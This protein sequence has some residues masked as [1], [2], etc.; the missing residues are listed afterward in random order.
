MPT[1]ATNRTQTNAINSGATSADAAQLSRRGVLAGA[2]T[3][4]VAI[5][6]GTSLAKAPTKP[7]PAATPT[8]P[9]GFYRL[10]VGDITGVALSDGLGVNPGSP[11]PT[12]AP[13]ATKDEVNAVLKDAFLPE[14]RFVFYFNGL[15]LKIGADLILIDAG[16]GSL[17]GPSGGKVEANIKAAGYN[18]DDIKA[19]VLTHAHGD[20]FGG[21]LTDAGTPR[22]KNARLIVNRAEH[23]FWTGAAPDLS[24]LRMPEETRK[25]FI[26]G[27]RKHLEAFKG[28]T[29]LVAPGDKLFGDALEL[30]DG[31]GHTPGH[32]LVMVRSGNEQLLN[33]ADCAHHYILNFRNPA[34]TVAFDADPASAVATR[35]KVFSMAA[36]DGVRV[37]GY[38]MPWPGVGHIREIPG[39]FEW[40]P[41][42]WGL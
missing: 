30:L 17:M 6:S 18:L 26:A 31:R 33:L 34:W 2:A 19:V 12:F 4:A 13:E 15:L 39:G 22:F 38:H 20:H 27:A 1:P 40:V 35:R 37:L 24:G 10:T 11:H 3:A 7:Q 16:A 41:Q 8:E 14:D 36:S 9:A 42:P 29:D 28:K 23:D 25:N 5:S 32:M 21:L